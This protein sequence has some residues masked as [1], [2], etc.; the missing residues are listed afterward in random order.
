MLKNS[1]PALADAFEN[2]RSKMIVLCYQLFSNAKRKNILQRYVDAVKP[3]L[4]RYLDTNVKLKEKSREKKSL[5][6][7]KK[8]T[9]VL[10]VMEHI[11]LSSRINELTEEIEDLRTEKAMRL[12]RLNCSDEKEF[13][14]F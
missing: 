5:V 8:E 4:D 2:L 3:D 9:P 12:S 1:I 10:N 13:K 14:T 7:P 11:R 6:A